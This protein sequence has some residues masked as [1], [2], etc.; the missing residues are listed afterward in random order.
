LFVFCV[1]RFCTCALFRDRAARTNSELEAATRQLIRLSAF[2]K[3]AN[4]SEPATWT[5]SGI[6]ITRGFPMSYT[7]LKE[8]ET[9]AISN[10]PSQI[11]FYVPEG[12]VVA[13]LE[14][15]VDPVNVNEINLTIQRGR[16]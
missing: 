3:L 2:D 4:V 5:T 15:N 11:T 10:G 1:M 12:S 16:A 8:S 13:H 9:S 7:Y 14:V 6:Q